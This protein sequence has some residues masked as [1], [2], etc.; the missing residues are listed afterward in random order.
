L[1]HAATLTAPQSQPPSPSAHVNLRVREITEADHAAVARLLAKGF[2]R[3]VWYY[4]EALKRLSRHPTPPDRSKYGFMM[5]ADGVVVGAVLLIFSTLPSGSAACMRCNV[6]SWYVEPEYKNYAALFTSR[7]LRHKDVTYVNISA[8]PA[9]R[10]II[11]AQ[12]FQLYSSGQYVAVPVL[13]LRS[14]DGP[15]QICGVQTAP[16]ALF[17]M[18][19]YEL[20]AAHAEFG[21]MSLWCLMSGRAYPF[22]FLPRRFKRVLPGVQ[23][24][25]CREIQDVVRFAGPLGRFLAARGKLVISIDSNG[26]IAGLPGRYVKGKSP[27]FFKGRNPPRPGDISYTQAAMFPWPW[28][29]SNRCPPENSSSKGR[30]TLRS[31]TATDFARARA[32][33]NRFD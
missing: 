4:V 13:H 7:A 2:Q 14:T 28:Y 5:E 23:L 1:A 22:V 19:D 30:Q 6:T 3:P 26:P 17:E 15:V 12:G 24:I 10:P 9:A 20:L 11:L 25:Y 18:S 29:V 27:R 32:D 8:R 31:R 16:D 33:F 21:C